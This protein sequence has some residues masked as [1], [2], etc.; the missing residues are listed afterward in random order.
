MRNRFSSTIVALLILTAFGHSTLVVCSGWSDSPAV[1]AACCHAAN[2]D[3]AADD[4]CARGET[5]Q[6]AQALQSVAP[7][8]VPTFQII[9]SESRID[10][11]T[12]LVGGVPLSA[13]TYRPDTYLLLS[14]LL[15]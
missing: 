6:H 8:I 11:P 12:P 10:A 2:C 5:Q 7:A 1:R 4:C 13:L 15:V 14:V 3:Q 9:V